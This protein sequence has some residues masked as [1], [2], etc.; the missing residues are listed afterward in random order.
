MTIEHF[1][2][3]VDAHNARL[4]QAVIAGCE[5]QAESN[6]ELRLRDLHETDCDSIG[7][8]SRCV[9]KA[10]ADYC[11]FNKTD[12]INVGQRGVMLRHGDHISTHTESAESD[13]GVAYWPSGD[14]SKIGSDVNQRA[15]L[16]AGRP[17]APYF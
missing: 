6:H 2:E 11:G 15:D 12:G 17:L 7:W 1:G 10:C 8:L 16:Q 9:A 13:I 4:I 14:V 5:G 3:D